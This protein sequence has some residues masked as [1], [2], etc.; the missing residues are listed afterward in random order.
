V[1][2][3]PPWIGGKLY[4]MGCC[5][6]SLGPVVVVRG[7]TWAVWTAPLRVLWIGLTHPAG[8]GTKVLSYCEADGREHFFDD[9]AG[10]LINVLAGEPGLVFDGFRADLHPL[11]RDFAHVSSVSDSPTERAHRRCERLR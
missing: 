8:L 2:P 9:G 10:D 7:L 1:G 4:A 5:L 6:V 3:A 11:L